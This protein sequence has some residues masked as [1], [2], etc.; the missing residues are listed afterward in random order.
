MI[1]KI[2]THILNSPPYKE[3]APRPIHNLSRN[4]CVYVCMYKNVPSVEDRNQES[5]R[6]LVKERI[7]NI[8]KLKTIFLKRFDD[9]LR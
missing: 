1:L 9:F 3:W 8:G 2:R 5:W 4:V 6:L 7:A